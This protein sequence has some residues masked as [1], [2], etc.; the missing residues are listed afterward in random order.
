MLDVRNRLALRHLFY[1]LACS[2]FITILTTGFQLYTDYTRDLSEIEE[3]LDQV[4]SSYLPAIIASRYSLDDDQLAILLKGI[5]QLKDIVYVAVSGDDVS[6]VVASAGTFSPQPDIERSY[7]LYYH[8]LDKDIDLGV[9]R[10]QVSLDAVVSRLQHR[11]FL[12][13]AA[14]GLKT[15][16]MS[17]LIL[18]IVHLL[19]IRHLQRISDF[20]RGLNTDSLDQRLKLSRKVQ[21]GQSND[22]LDEIVDAINGMSERI[23]SDIKTINES[24]ATQKQ[25]NERL[26]EKNQALSEEIERRNAMEASLQDTEH[27]LRRAQRMEAIGNLAGGIAHDFNNILFPIMGYAELL[28]KKLPDA[29]HEMEHAEAVFTASKR[30]RD[31][32]KQILTL[33]RDSEDERMLMSVETVVKEVFSFMQATLP[34][35]I[36]FELDI[37]PDCC[38]INGD[39][40]RVHQIIM[41]LVTNAYHAVEDRGGHIHLSLGHARIDQEQDID[42]RPGFYALVRVS[43]NGSGIAPEILGKIFD[44]YFT[45]KE[46][47]KGTGLGLATCN[48][49]V[50]EY[51]GAIL[52]ESS[53]GKGTTLY[54]Y[55]P[56]VAASSAEPD[57]PVPVEVRGTEEIMVVDD[58]VSIVELETQIL[59]TLGYQVCAF[60]SSHDAL[61]AFKCSPDRFDLVLTDMNMPKLTGLELTSALREV[62]EDIPVILC[63]GLNERCDA[64]DL[65]DYGFVATLGKP[66]TLSHLAV[67]IRRALDAQ[68]SSLTS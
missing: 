57:I 55:F 17:F 49:I 3:T 22:E 26:E 38:S 4:H 31:L 6:S 12:I 53:I 68:D 48:A 65:R 36:A 54:V 40:I 1:V 63:T 28:M 39:P 21:E 20:T 43:D 66:V 5:E 44:P 9:L 50:E 23:R 35:N 2:T 25:L 52:V 58:E 46:Q 33:S 32:V 60:S 47:G 61:E 18:L 62:R 51:G 15:F 29:S 7:P 41:N 30:G 27:Q 45:T 11:F 19:T 37:E 64:K 13:I 24:V 67:V 14:N 56:C 34:A 8:F 42:V 16:M 59:T 10:I